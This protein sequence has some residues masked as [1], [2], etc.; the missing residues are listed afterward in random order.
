[1]ENKDRLEQGKKFLEILRKG[2][3]NSK[4][5]QLKATNKKVELTTRQFLKAYKQETIL[6]WRT[7]LVPTEIFYATG[8]LPFTP[9]MFCAIISQNQSAMRKTFQKAEENQYESKLCSFLKNIIGGMY[10]GITP[11]PD[12]IISSPS[13]CNGIGSILYDASRYYGRDYFYLNI[14][15]DVGSPEAINYLAN[16]L[17]KLVLALCK[18]TGIS[19]KE[20]EQQRLPQAIEF[21]NQAAKYWKQINKLRQNVPS[22]MSGRE[23]LDYA[24]VLS[25]NWGCQEI[26]EIYKLLCSELEDRVKKRIGAVPDEKLR[27]MWLHLRPYYS[28]KILEIIEKQ[29]AAIVF[30][31][32]NFPSRNKMNT[33]KPYQSLAKEILSNSGR[34]RISTQRAKYLVYLAKTYKVDGV[35]HFAHENCDWDKTTFP[36]VSYFLQQKHQVPLLNLNGDCLIAERDQLI[37]TR[38]Q[39]FLEGLNTRREVVDRYRMQRCSSIIS[40]EFFTGIDIGATTTKTVILDNNRDIVGWSILAT[41]SDNKRS[42]GRTLEQSLT[43]AGNLSQTKLKAI[44]A[45]GVGRCNVPFSSKE[46]TEITCHTQG[47][48]YFFPDAKTIIDI[49]GQDTKVI[50]IETGKFRMN[51]ACAAGT[52]KFIETIA[53]TLNLNLNELAE[54]DAK[55]NKALILSRMCTVFAESEVVNLIAKGA[56]LEEIIRGIHEMTADKAITLL[57]QLSSNFSLPIAMSGGVALNQGVVRAVER[58]LGTKIWVPDNPQLVGALGAAIIAFQGNSSCFSKI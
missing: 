33:E 1:M 20:V 6:A 19:I 35:I 34:Y 31:E 9:E 37:K 2:V 21:S 7:F 43:M 46:I 51:D 25:Q 54:L 8:V 57:R 17:K 39:A 48:K 36:T 5:K 53:K 10:E 32:V 47:I 26:V 52:G 29:N 16:Q 24:A 42:I 38:I 22:P 30:E 55:A 49:G 4:I 11:V 56:L 40:K 44:V 12:I 27:L 15:L 3:K 41:G 13:F 58:N 18:K 50:L 14:P 45:T 28:D 23:A